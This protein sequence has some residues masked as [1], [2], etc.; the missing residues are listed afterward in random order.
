MKPNPQR[1]G[2]L[3]GIFIF[4]SGFFASVIGLAYGDIVSSS[5]NLR[6][7]A[8]NDGNPEMVMNSTGLGIGTTAPSTNLHVLGNAYI[9]GNTGIRVSQ[10]LST[11]EIAGTLGFSSQSVTSNVTLGSNTVVLVDPATAGGN[12]TLRLPYAGNVQGRSYLIKKTSSSYSVWLTGGGNYIDGDT[13]VTLDTAT[14][15]FPYVQV[16]SDGQQWYIISGGTASSTALSANLIGYWK[17]DE[18]SG[19]TAYDSSVNGNN[20]LLKNT[21]FANTTTSGAIGRALNFVRNATTDSTDYVVITH[22]GVSALKNATIM[23]WVDLDS[24]DNGAAEIVTLDQITIRADYYWGT[25]PEYGTC[26][27][28]RRSASPFTAY[29]N[30]GNLIAGTGWR[31]L[32]YS[33]SDTDSLQKL[34]LDGSVLSSNTYSGTLNTGAANIVLGK[35]TGG[36]DNWD[37]DG[38]MDEVRVYNRTLTADEVKAIYQSR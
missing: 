37:F 26:G 3:G 16:Q 23:A 33:N 10:P 15:G 24:K 17:L 36:Q 31:H 28:T 1:S 34:Y 7:D 8:N 11:L 29:T 32:A 6:L 35:H 18:T 14:T 5:G 12:L 22:G 19:T 13:L 9:T 27:I 38:R 21:S 20:G 2:S 25:P 30:S 4:F